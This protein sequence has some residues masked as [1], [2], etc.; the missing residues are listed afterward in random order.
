MAFWEFL[1]QKDGDRSWLPLESPT[2]EILEGRYR[3]VGRSSRVN[4]PIEI[5]IAHDAL[6]ESM[7]VRRT[8]KRSGCTNQD[9]LVVIMPFTQLQPGDWELY[10][11]GDLMADMMGEGW[12]YGVKLQVLP[13]V[14]DAE[15]WEPDTPAAAEL[16]T[17]SVGLSGAASLLPIQPAIAFAA[18]ETLAE[19]TLAATPQLAAF[20]ISAAAEQSALDESQ[21]RLSELNSSENLSETNPSETPSPAVILSETLPLSLSLEQEM[22]I[23]RRGEPLILRGEIHSAAPDSQELSLQVRVRLYAPQN[24][25]VLFDQIYA[26]N[27]A[28]APMPFT[29][30]VPLPHHYETYLMLG[31]VTLESGG[32]NAELIASQ[33]FKVTTDLHELLESIANSFAD[34]PDVLPPL[35]A[36]S[37]PS[38]LPGFSQPAVLPPVQFQPAQTVLPP[39]LRSAPPENGNG[40]KDRRSIE[41]PTFAQEPAPQ[42]EPAAQELAPQEPVSVPASEVPPSSVPASKAPASAAEPAQPVDALPPVNDDLSISDLFFTEQSIAANHS[43][44]IGVAERGIEPPPKAPVSKTGQESKTDPASPQP[45]GSVRLPQGG[46]AFTSPQPS[47]PITAEIDPALDWQHADSRKPR[48]PA[49]DAPLAPEDIA[50]RSLNLQQRFL[51]RLQSL[52]SDRPLSAAPQEQP[53]PAQ[54]HT[55]DAEAPSVSVFDT[56]QSSQPGNRT[57][58][59]GEDAHLARDEFVID[60]GWEEMAAM[61]QRSAPKKSWQT[62]AQTPSV[63]GLTLSPDEPL[64]VPALNLPSENLIGGSSTLVLVKLPDCPAKLAVKLWLIDRQSRLLLDGPHW[65]T[66]FTPDGFGQWMS[67]IELFLPQGYLEVQVE[68][69]SVEIMTQRESEKTTEARSI[70]PPLSQFSHDSID[71]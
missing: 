12:Q 53:A 25:Q 11:T 3:V 63:P 47:K 6:T 37:L 9:G 65:L 8:Q 27:P 69:I 61:Q 55:S 33:T 35:E 51:S 7:P 4:T 71:I 44:E 13:V 39:Q 21:H 22:Y 45:T 50:F 46:N 64:P 49:A 62:A 26:L 40:A 28:A 29:C 24:A 68:A 14:Q 48:K 16:S 2:V 18:S 41:L 66:D 57:Q 38:E 23:V 32:S 5:R 36:V 31:E 52:A 56:K 15:A 30:A 59:I 19:P 10:C 60:E 20:A 58:P 17:L 67:R 1:L 34:L 42:E 54:P 43:L 70:E